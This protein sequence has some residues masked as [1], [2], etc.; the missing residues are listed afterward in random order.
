MRGNV[1]KKGNRWYIRYYIGRDQNGKWKQKWEGSW[2]TKKEAERVLRE[3]ITELEST[4]ERKADSST[5]S[6]FLHYWLDTYCAPRF[7]TNTVRRYR[8]N[9]ENHVIP[10]IGNVQLNRLQPKDIQKMYSALMS[11]GLSGTSIRYVHNN[12]H[13]ALNYAVKQQLILR[14]PADLVDAPTVSRYETVTLSPA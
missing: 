3:R 11:G 9:I 6:V 12:L 14:N 7:A 1:T 5:M 10:Y 8:V 13:K 2:D 4:Y